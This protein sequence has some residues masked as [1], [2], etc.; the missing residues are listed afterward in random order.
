MTTPIDNLLS[1][2]T[3]TKLRQAAETLSQRYRMGESPY[4]TED[5]H[6]LAYLAMRFPATYEAISH[7][8]QWIE[9]DAVETF[10]DLGAGPGT[11]FLAAQAHFTHI[12]E[13]TLV[14]TDPAFISL[15]K[16]II[17][18]PMVTWKRAT[19]PCILPPHDLVLMSY[20]LGEM[21]DPEKVLKAAWMAT[22]KFLVIIEPGTP[23]GYE[24]IMKIRDTLLAQGGF[25]VAPC[26]HSLKCPMQG[27]DWCH[28]PAR[29][30]RNWLHRFLKS[31]TMSFEDEKYSYVIMS[32][33]EVALPAARI[34]GPINFKKGQV[35]LPLCTSEGQIET[36]IVTQ[37]TKELYKQCRKK[38]WGDVVP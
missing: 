4:L 12:K 10:L 16:E 28:F 23:A 7:V 2:I 38:V 35:I 1:G 26:P 13:A 33:T 20:S 18:A 27:G 14:E 24:Q 34:V 31:G 22:N 6:Y 11:G 5:A 9:P 17:D 8:L 19:L 30:E 37:R 32:K 3:P 29:V 25:M 15:G 36:T 21:D